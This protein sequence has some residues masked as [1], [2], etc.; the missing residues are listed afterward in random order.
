MREKKVTVL[1]GTKVA[2]HRSSDVQHT[3]LDA[4]TGRFLH[5]GSLPQGVITLQCQSYK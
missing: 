3:F 4:W 5:G 2:H 1:A